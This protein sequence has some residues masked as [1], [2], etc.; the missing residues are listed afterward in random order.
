MILQM[1][2]GIYVNLRFLSGIHEIP[3]KKQIM[4]KLEERYK[5]KPFIN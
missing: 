2:E 4:Q 3:Q 5:D 1:L